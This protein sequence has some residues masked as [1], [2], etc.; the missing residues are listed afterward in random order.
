LAIYQ[1]SFTVERPGGIS[2]IINERS[3]VA[4]RPDVGGEIQ[5]QFANA[6]IQV[7]LERVRQPEDISA[8][9]R[10][11][12]AR[13][14]TL[15]AAGGDGTINSVAAV[16]VD[17]GAT[18]GVLPM[19]T[20]NHFA[21]DLGIPLDLPSAVTIIVG[22][23]V[24]QVDVG[25]VNGR[26][27]VNNSSVGLYPRMVWEREG[28]Q[29]RGRRKWV[30]FTI[31]MLRTWRQYRLAVAHLDVDGKTAVVRTPFIFVGN[32]Q[33]TAEGFRMGG[34]ARLDEGRLSV[35]VAPECG[36]FEILA[37]PVRALTNRLGEAVPFAGFQA[38]AVSVDLGRHRLNVA[39]DGEIAVMRTPLAY[40]IRPR[41]LRVITPP[42][43]GN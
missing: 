3:G 40:H 34:R 29:R 39:L 16:A 23:H 21:K 5:S 41:A 10:Q 12:A 19:G 42:P 15:V 31:A 26:V 28:E 2:I 35:F 18:L 13:G 27:F 22:R 33:Y 9:A 8:R 36:R 14:D 11:A 24:R 6:G 1:Y 38:E 37:L 17:T 32:N 43:I 20:L 25:E 4:A 7:R 30:A